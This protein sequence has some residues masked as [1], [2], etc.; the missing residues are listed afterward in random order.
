MSKDISDR[1]RA[2]RKNNSE[3]EIS[4]TQEFFTP[5]HLCDEML[6]MI[7]EED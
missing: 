5:K 3:L 7:P 2:R 4:G 1:R 6:D